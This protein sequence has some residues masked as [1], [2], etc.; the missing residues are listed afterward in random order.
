MSRALPDL[1]R[2]AMRARSDSGLG[3]G[4]GCDAG[5]PGGG[6]AVLEDD[7]EDDGDNDGDGEQLVVPAGREGGP[8]LYG[9]A[10]GAV[11]VLGGS[12]ILAGCES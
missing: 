11:L 9:W 8:S 4:L 2:L 3:L 5:T 7:D 6:G 10:D 1:M 12:G